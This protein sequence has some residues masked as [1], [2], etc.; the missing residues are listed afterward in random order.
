MLYSACPTCGTTLGNKQLKLE[1]EKE[2]ICNNPELSNDEK[3]SKIK[4]AIN[5]LKMRRY[6]C[7]MRLISYIDT[8]QIIM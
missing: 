2:K 5:N 6:C 7:K 1:K 3:E 4:E 8:V